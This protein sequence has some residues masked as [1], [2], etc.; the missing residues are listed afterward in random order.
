[1]FLILLKHHQSKFQDEKRNETFFQNL[2]TR[3]TIFP[4]E[5]SI[6]SIR[7]TKIANS[8]YVIRLALSVSFPPVIGAVVVFLNQYA[9]FKNHKKNVFLTV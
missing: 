5:Y 3:E 2:L 9:A 8:S 7:R 6:R 4:I 1:M